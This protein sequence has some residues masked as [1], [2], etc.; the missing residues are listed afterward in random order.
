MINEERETEAERLGER[1]RERERQ[2]QRE[3]RERKTR[4]L[5]KCILFELAN[6]LIALSNCY[7]I[8]TVSKKNFTSIK[9]LTFFLT[10]L[11]KLLSS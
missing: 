5:K 9:R 10:K 2:K 7:I 6:Y 11:G 3:K 8:S 4:V 1:E